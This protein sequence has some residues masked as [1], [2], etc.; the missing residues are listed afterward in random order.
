MLNL[1]A[2]T[3]KRAYLFH[4]KFDQHNFLHIYDNSGEEK[5]DG[6]SHD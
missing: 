1:R 2:Y 6:I 5:I 4:F 3:I